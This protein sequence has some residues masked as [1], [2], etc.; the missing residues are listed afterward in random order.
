MS[1]IAH[2]G[3]PGESWVLSFPTTSYRPLLPI[4]DTTSPCTIT[5]WLMQRHVHGLPGNYC[6]SSNRRKLPLTPG[7]ILPHSSTS[8]E[9]FAFLCRLQTQVS[10]VTG[11]SG[12]EHVISVGT[13]TTTETPSTTTETIQPVRLKKEPCSKILLHQQSKYYCI[14]KVSTTALVK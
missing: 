4:A 13:E 7:A 6:N 9:S 14:G 11:K 1:F 10:C 12:G 3:R 5:H 2:A 8:Q